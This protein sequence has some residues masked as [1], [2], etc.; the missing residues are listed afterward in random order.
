MPVKM[1]D[2]SDKPMVERQAIA[3]GTLHLFPDT[4]DAIKLGAIEKGDVF[5][6]AQIAGVHGVKSTCTLIPMC[7]QIPITH[8]DIQFQMRSDKIICTCEV[9]ANYKT[10]V[11]ME[12]LV[13]ATIAL[14]TVW[15]M[16]K[17][18]EKDEEGQYRDTRINDIKVEVK[19][20]GEPDERG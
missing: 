5:A 1:V 19:V 16:V 12:A 3:K 6:A 7:H 11:E 18:L 2:V 17:Y 10:G 15:D 13:G 4:I 14:L 8:S 20:K 9:R